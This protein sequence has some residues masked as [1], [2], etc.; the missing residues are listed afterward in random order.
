VILN[1]ALASWWST[2]LQCHLERSETE[3]K[4][5]RLLFPFT[6]LPSLEIQ[7]LAGSFQTML[8]KACRISAYR[9]SLLKRPNPL[10]IRHCCSERL[11]N[12]CLLSR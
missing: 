8:Q 6:G 1:L 5:L 3:S 12:S 10:N 11:R 2:S 4:D 7:T 9:D